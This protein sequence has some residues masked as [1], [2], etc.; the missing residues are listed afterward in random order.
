M[1]PKSRFSKP[2]RPLSPLRDDI[3]LAIAILVIVLCGVLISIGGAHAA[4]WVENAPQ[5][6]EVPRV[7][8]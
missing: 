5:I 4:N 8:D 2:R 6:N 3:S 7:V 1:K